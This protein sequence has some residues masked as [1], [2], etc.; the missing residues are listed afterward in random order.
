MD[1]RLHEDDR[2]KSYI[3]RILF[4]HFNSHIACGSSDD[5]FCGIKVVRIQVRHLLFGDAP[6][7]G[8]GYFTYLRLERIR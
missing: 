4:C 2:I 7:I 5:A 8:A 6:D 1:P 3:N